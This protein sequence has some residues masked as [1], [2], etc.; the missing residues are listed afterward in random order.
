MHMIYAISR[1][2]ISG[3]QSIQIEKAER[4]AAQAPPQR[5]ALARRV[6]CASDTINLSASGGSIF[7]V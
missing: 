5:Q 2:N 3:M 4:H 6:R 1:L 7:N